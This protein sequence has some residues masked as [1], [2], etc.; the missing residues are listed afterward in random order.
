MRL[1]NR[2]ITLIVNSILDF[3][4]A[5]VFLGGSIEPELKGVY[6]VESTDYTVLAE[7]FKEIK[8]KR[9]DVLVDIGCGKGRVVYWWLKKG[10]KN[11]LVGIEINNKV[12]LQTAKRLKAFI[13]AIICSG[14]ALEALPPDGTIFYLCNPCEPFLFEEILDR[15]YLLDT[16][17]KTVIY[18]NF[19]YFNPDKFIN[20]WDISI[21]RIKTRY[22]EIENAQVAIFRSK[23]LL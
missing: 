22:T 8:I 10:L 19:P 7:I 11:K 1:I 4:N 6:H 15:I 23:N 14:N 9:E 2:I 18:Y 5:G 13:N 17:N 20:K 12:A 3:T 16:L 21:S